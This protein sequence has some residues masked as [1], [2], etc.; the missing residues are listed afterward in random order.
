MHISARGRT[1]ATTYPGHTYRLV[2]GSSSTGRNSS[3]ADAARDA[4]EAST[5][6]IRE[7]QRVYT[8]GDGGFRQGETDPLVA[9][10]EAE[11]SFDDQYCDATGQHWLPPYPRPA[12]PE[13]ALFSHGCV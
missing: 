5:L 10:I 11:R 8:I 9:A 7:D 6:S 1:T 12:S 13:I 2:H 4:A 3:S